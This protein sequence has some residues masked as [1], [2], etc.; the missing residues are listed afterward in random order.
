MRLRSLMKKK[1]KVI[2]WEKFRFNGVIENT[3]RKTAITL[4]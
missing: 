3:L 4:N 1:E 2:Y